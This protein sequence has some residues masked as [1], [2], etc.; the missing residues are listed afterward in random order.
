MEGCDNTR[1]DTNSNHD[2]SIPENLTAVLVYHSLWEL[3]FFI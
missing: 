2:A 1:E 3:S